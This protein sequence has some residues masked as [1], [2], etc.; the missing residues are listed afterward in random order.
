MKHQVS[1]GWIIVHSPV[2]NYVTTEQRPRVIA[3]APV[4]LL[5][6]LSYTNPYL[7]RAQGRRSIGK[8]DYRLFYEDL[9]IAAYSTS[10]ACVP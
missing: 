2:V 6:R 5:R 9:T 10:K 4:L 7:I 8:Y 3:Y 1:V